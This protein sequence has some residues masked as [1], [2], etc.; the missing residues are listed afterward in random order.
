MKLNDLKFGTPIWILWL[1]SSTSFNR[2]T[3][4]SDIDDR[5]EKQQLRHRSIGFVTKVLD[6]LIM[7]H[8]SEAVWT[9][10]GGDKSICDGITIP[11][12]AIVRW[13]LAKM[14]VTER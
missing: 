1:D 11:R 14:G 10:S 13:G 5:R 8:Q 9:Y 3:H 12:V 4:L 2:W 7:L 6:E